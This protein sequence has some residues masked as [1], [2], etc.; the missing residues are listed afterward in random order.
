MLGHHRLRWLDTA[1][2]EIVLELSSL[3]QAIGLR[4]DQVSIATHETAEPIELAPGQ[5]HRL[6]LPRSADHG[7][8][9]HSLGRDGLIDGE[10][11]S[12]AWLAEQIDRQRDRVALVEHDPDRPPAMTLDRWLS[13]EA[14]LRL[15]PDVAEGERALV[16]A[17]TLEALGLSEAHSQRLDQLDR[18]DSALS[19]VAA[20]L[21]TR[22]GLLVLDARSAALDADDELA[23]VERIK[24]LAGTS[25]TLVVLSGENGIP[26][27][28]R[29]PL[30]N[31]RRPLRSL[32]RR[33][34]WSILA[35][36]TRRALGVLFRR[37]AAVTSLVGLPVLLMMSMQQVLDLRSGV[38][39][40]QAVLLIC[41]PL[42]ALALGV[43]R[44]GVPRSL[45]HRFGL[46]PDQAIVQSLLAA[47]TVVI[48]FLLCV[49]LAT[50]LLPLD[51]W[52]LAS[53]SEVLLS[54]AAGMTLGLLARTA[55]QGHRQMALLLASLAGTCQAAWV[56]SLQP[57]PLSLLGWTALWSG[58]ALLLGARHR[59]SRAGS[60]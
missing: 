19:L 22:P 33:P 17:T 30:D 2:P 23:M 39:A 24:P 8:L 10:L 7:A 38:V 46:L 37:P 13:D 16:I 60:P 35:C 4:L 52:T 53:G 55:S 41:S 44:E 28:Y 47:G 12:Q 51:V 56:L 32:L 27:R 9:M 26:L 29:P 43:A 42:A 1:G 11:F 40:A 34:H 31:Q 49:G 18:L 25:L 57:G 20:G 5:L 21:L 3:G 54:A 59:L 58:L 14:L 48:Q 6:Q 50:S 36:L 45:I 15:G